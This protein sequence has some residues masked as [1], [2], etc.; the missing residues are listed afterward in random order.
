MYLED[1]SVCFD[2]LETRKGVAV[3]CFMNINT[4][5]GPTIYFKQ[6]AITKEMGLK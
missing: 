4:L 2:I 5:Y 1:Q 6:G 3:S